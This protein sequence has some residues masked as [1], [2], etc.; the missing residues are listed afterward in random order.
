MEAYFIAQICLF[1][2]NFAPR[3]WAFCQGQ[4]LSIA[5]NEA[6]FALIGTIYGGDGQNTFALPDF[7]GRIPV[8]AGQGPGLSNISLGEQAGTPFT[9]LNIN[10]M[11]AHTH[12]P[13][14]A[15]GVSSA[16]GNTGNPAGAVVAQTPA[17][18]YA[19][20]ANATQAFTGSS[21][22]VSPAGGSQPFSKMMP[23]L[24][25]NFVIALEGIF[26]SRN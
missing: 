13:T 20:A 1:A 12:T 15:V 4:L 22:V 26:P 16:A 10:Q 2:G 24:G 5:Q 7:R 14:I 3:S 17:N 18:F 9:T 21:I 11:P 8:G 6:L 19:P 25:M 23:Y